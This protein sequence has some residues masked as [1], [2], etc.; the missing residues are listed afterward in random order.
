MSV[1]IYGS[2]K[3][4]DVTSEDVDI[5]Y[6]YSGSREELG[7]LQLKPM[8][9][10]ITNNEFRKMFGG[11]G[12]YKLRLPSTIF[13]QLGFYLMLIKPKSFEVQI[14]DCSF[15]VTDNAN[16]IEIS[17]KGIVIPKLQ[18]QGNGA[19]TGYQVEYFDNQG[20]KIKNFHRNNYFL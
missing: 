17:K 20:V 5:L 6:A 14:S 11:D 19:L 13:N 3:L 7:D 15:V 10:N 12:A 1:G 18:F 2:K 8:F 4:A 9:P 16:A